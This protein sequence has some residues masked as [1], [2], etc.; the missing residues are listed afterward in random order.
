MSE[1]GASYGLDKVDAICFLVLFIIFLPIILLYI[2]I[3][4]LTN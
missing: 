4:N 1:Y 3:D 2:L